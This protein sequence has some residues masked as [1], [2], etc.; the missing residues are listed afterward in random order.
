[1]L[2][3]LKLIAEDFIEE[4]HLATVMPLYTELVAKTKAEPLCLAYD[5]FIDH[6]DPGHFIFIESWPDEAALQAHVDSE[7]FQRLVPQIDA[8]AR[9]EGTFLRMKP[10]QP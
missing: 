10:F 6:Q 2:R 4:K 7:H 5:L 1:M 9:Q 3:I 8:L